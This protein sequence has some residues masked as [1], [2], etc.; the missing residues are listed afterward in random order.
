MET[1]ALPHKNLPF[2][3]SSISFPPIR[4]WSLLQDR[5]FAHQLWSRRGTSPT[6]E[7][8]RK[9]FHEAN[10]GRSLSSPHTDLPLRVSKGGERGK[11]IEVSSKT[12]I[13]PT[14]RTSVP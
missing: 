8:K 4:Y 12:R 2:S 6:L 5:I 10:T 13:A 11:V 9:I 14:D 1:C 3:A 7:R